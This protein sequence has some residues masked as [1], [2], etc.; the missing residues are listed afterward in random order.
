MAATPGHWLL[1]PSDHYWQPLAIAGQH[2]LRTQCS[3]HKS[4][5]EDC[6]RTAVA[7][8]IDYIAAGLRQHSH[9]WLDVSSRLLTKI[10]FCPSYVRV[11]DMG[12]PLQREDGSFLYAGATFVSLHFL[13]EYICA[14]KAL[15]SLSILFTLCRCTILSN[16]YTRCTNV[17][18]HCRLVQKV[19]SLLI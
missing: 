2:S 9:S 10:L 16:Y 3:S 11:W 6:L 17:F 15:R 14:V 19:M 7:Q 5:N 1:N 8:S 18:C 4:L 13:Q 12:P